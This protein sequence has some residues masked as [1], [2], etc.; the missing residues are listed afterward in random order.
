MHGFFRTKHLLR[1]YAKGQAQLKDLPALRVLIID[2]IQKR[3]TVTRDNLRDIGLMT[4]NELEDGV[5]CWDTIQKS[6]PQVIFM[7]LEIPKVDVAELVERILKIDS[8]IK[9]I[10][11][12]PEQAVIDREHWMLP[13]GVFAT[14]R[15]PLAK[16][17]LMDLISKITQN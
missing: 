14:V 7:D 15:K 5:D 11:L 16:N 3:R 9:V 6:R 12:L 17:D 1:W 4:T 13:K 8:T 10:L 2:D